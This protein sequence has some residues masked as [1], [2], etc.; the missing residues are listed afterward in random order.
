MLNRVDIIQDIAN[1]NLS[2]FGIG[3]TLLTVLISFVLSKKDEVKVYSDIY[4]TSHMDLSLKGKIQYSIQYIKYLRK[5]IIHIML[6]SLLSIYSY[7]F[8]WIDKFVNTDWIIYAMISIA[9]I[10]FIYSIFLIICI[11]RFFWKYTKPN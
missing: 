7:L 4:K 2:L 6:V 10:S 5:V 3:I 8:Y 1:F 9:G 11:M